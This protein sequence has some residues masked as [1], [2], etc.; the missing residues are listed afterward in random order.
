MQRM[1][2]EHEGQSD[3]QNLQGFGKYDFRDYQVPYDGK[4]FLVGPNEYDFTSAPDY[5]EKIVRA[6]LNSVV[7]P[8]TAVIKAPVVT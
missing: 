3:Q 6:N 4:Q 5:D 7:R 2:N 8:K 1:K